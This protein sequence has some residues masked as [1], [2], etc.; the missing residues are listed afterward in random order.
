M[1]DTITLRFL[2]PA[3]FPN[4]ESVLAFV[5]GPGYEAMTY[6]VEQALVP[7][8]SWSEDYHDGFL[9]VARE[10]AGEL[11]HDLR[12]LALAAVR[13]TP[14]RAIL[15]EDAWYRHGRSHL[16]GMSVEVGWNDPAVVREFYRLLVDPQP[17]PS[18]A[19]T[20]RLAQLEAEA[21]A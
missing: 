10:A 13:R 21:R 12:Q 14:V 18:P 3:R 7:R 6:T 4:L 19:L 5:E 9:R 2:D 15:K 17:T 8:G 1:S 11:A 20:E 16:L